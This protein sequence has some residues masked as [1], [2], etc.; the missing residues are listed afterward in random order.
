MLCSHS[1]GLSFYGQLLEQ[2]SVASLF[3]PTGF[4][5]VT[6]CYCYTLGKSVQINWWWWWWF[7]T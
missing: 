3:R 6:H 2:L 4:F 1:K 5:S 7:S